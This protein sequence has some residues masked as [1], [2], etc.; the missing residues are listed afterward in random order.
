MNLHVLLFLR[1]VSSP[2]VAW[3]VDRRELEERIIRPYANR[4]RLIVGGRGIQADAVERIQIVRTKAGSSTFL[5]Q[6][7]T[8]AARGQVDWFR[9]EGGTDVTDDLLEHAVVT[10]DVE[11]RVDPRDVFVVH[12]RNG[13]L[14]DAMF[15]FLRALD[16]HP[17]EWSELLAE[18]GEGSPYV[19][20]ILKKG[21]A[22]AA[23]FVVLLTGDDLAMLREPLRK[24]GEAA[25]ET[26]LTP[27]ARPN[28]LFEAGM[29]FGFAE[30]RT[31]L[32]EIG[33]LR[34]FSDIFGRHAV[35]L[36]NDTG[37]RQDLALRLKAGGCAVRMTGNDW[38]TAGDFSEEIA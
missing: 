14:R 10:D 18:A 30:R 37:P 2:V 16:L 31:I 27:Q 15:T 35:H 25:H 32:V 28:V 20:E 38:R 6:T 24:P 22:R 19:G 5:P 8:F 33:T 26:T 7:K 13:R 21:F 29:A 3:D 4:Q 36:T 9:P 17:M 12:G 11:P 1:S 34:P 23:A